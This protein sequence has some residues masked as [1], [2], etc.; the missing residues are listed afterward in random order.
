MTSLKFQNMHTT[1]K[2][3]TRASVK[4]SKLSTLWFNTGTLCNLECKNCYIESSPRN[5]RLTYLTV[6]DITPYLSELN[7]CPNIGFTGGEP[8]LNPSIISLLEEVLKRGHELLVLT[9]ANRVIKKHRVELLRLKE[10]YGHKLKL[11]ISLDHFSKEL[12]D[13]ERGIGAFDRTLEEL[14]WLYD[15][16]FDLSIA[17]RSLAN[18]TQEESLAGHQ[19]LLNN[20]NI[21]IDLS[22]KLVIFPEMDSRDVPEI[23][24]AC[25]GILNKRPEDQMCASERMI[26]KRKGDDSPVVMP[27]TLLAYDEKFILGKTL[28]DSREE[29]YLNHRFCA[30]FCVL[31]GASCS[32]TK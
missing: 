19:Q 1:A 14:K 26:V 27:C 8:F 6:N 7:D 32:K 2:G 22:E 15:H 4:L 20:F 29:V 3:E 18:E 10:C 9:N 16:G 21:Q 13:Q 31:G 25:W 11:R 28:S 30:E 17:S 23:T 5:D 12:H 24:T